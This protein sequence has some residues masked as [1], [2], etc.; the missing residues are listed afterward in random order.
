MVFCK[1]INKATFFSIDNI[2]KCLLSTNSAYWNHFWKIMSHWRLDVMAADFK[3]HKNRKQL[4]LF[5]IVIY[6][7]CIF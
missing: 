3:M 5:E 2:R 4:G 6:L 7:I 1:N